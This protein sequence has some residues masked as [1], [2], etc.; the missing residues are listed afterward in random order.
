[1]KKVKYRLLNRIMSIVFLIWVVAI[2]IKVYK[3]TSIFEILFSSIFLVAYIIFSAFIITLIA[4]FLYWRI[5]FDNEQFI[6]RTIFKKP[7]TIRY[8]DIEKI[9]IKYINTK[10]GIY[11]KLTFQLQN[12]DIQ[13]YISLPENAEN[14]D[15]FLNFLM[16]KTE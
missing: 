12:T 3:P 16:I 6:F 5:D 11:D 9:D 2:F 13:P 10:N 14:Y 15:D 4:Y 7:L 8:M 1:M